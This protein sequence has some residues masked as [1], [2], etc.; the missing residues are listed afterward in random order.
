MLAS[1]WGALVWLIFLG[2]SRSCNIKI[3]ASNEALVSHVLVCHR[4]SIVGCKMG[5][6]YGAEVG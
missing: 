4:C 6:I 5:A 3:G 1:F 2:M